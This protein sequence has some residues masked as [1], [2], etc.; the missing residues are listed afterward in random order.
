MNWIGST[1]LR[2][3]CENQIVEEV[4]SPDNGTKAVVFERSCGATTG[5]STQ[6]S[7]LPRNNALGD[8]PGNAFIADTD[9]GKAPSAPYG[10]PEVMLTWLGNRE[11]RVSYH[12]DAR[13]FT[14]VDKVGSIH[15]QFVTFQSGTTSEISISKNLFSCTNPP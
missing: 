1:A 4:F 12:K 11:L 2:G 3:T 7:L 6:V 13:I 9:H 8:Q 15:V 10:G 14:S 5:F